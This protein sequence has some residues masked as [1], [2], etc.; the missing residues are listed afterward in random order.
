MTDSFLSSFETHLR[1]T[2]A[3]RIASE[4]VTTLRP[5]MDAAM[6]A[7]FALMAIKDAITQ[8]EMVADAVMLNAEQLEALD[9][10]ESRL[11]LL[12]PRVKMRR[13]MV[14]LLNPFGRAPIC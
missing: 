13:S 3:E 2:R 7:R 6:R 4:Q 11:A 12:R 5:D 10:A 8:L 1:Q 14:H 9:D